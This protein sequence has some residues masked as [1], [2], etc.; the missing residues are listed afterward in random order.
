MK[1]KLTRIDQ[2]FNV[3]YGN[4]LDMNKM[5]AA[6]KS[7]G[8]AFVGRRGNNQ[9]V[10]GYVEAIPGVVP[11]PAGALTVA[12]GGSYLLSAFVQQREF[13]TAQNVAVLTPKDEMMTLTRRVYYAACI[14]HNRF[15]YSAFGRE[16]NRTLSTIQVPTSVPEWVDTALLPTHNGLAEAAA[17]AHP[18][19]SPTDWQEFKIGSLFEIKKGK[20][21]TKADRLPGNTRFI[22]ASEKNNGV[23]DYNDLEPTFLG[24]QITVPY[25][26]N[27]VGWAF[28]QDQP[29]FACDDVNVLVPKK[30][31]SKWA[32]LFVATVIK[33]EKA[34][35]TYG[36]KWTMERMQNTPIRLPKSHAGN[37]DWEFMTQFMRGLPFSAA[38][39]SAE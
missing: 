16:A 29:F 23:T 9:G 4:K 34:R 14:R 28:Y 37:P 6:S 33:H 15:R 38:I 20:R 8:I 24:G 1:P 21:L 30:A 36:F 11:F 13:Y 2:L 7:D 27:S 32:L 26:G 39:E 22:G 35:Y 19:T 31:V 18:L 3:V 25:N 5:Q 10:S 17:A 12:L